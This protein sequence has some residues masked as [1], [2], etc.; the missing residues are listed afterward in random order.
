MAFLFC[1][2]GAWAFKDQSFGIG[3]GYYSQNVLNKIS[4]S[5][6]GKTS[7][8]GASMYP[9]S[10]QYD[11]RFGDAWYMTPRL[12]YTLATRSD[13][14]DSSK[15]SF[16]HLLLP[17]GTNLSEGSGS[18]WDWYAGPGLIQYKIAGAGGT[19]TMNNGTGTA[20]FARPGDDATILKVT[21]NLGT[22]RLFNQQTRIGA[23]L[24][25]ENLFSSSKRTQSL[26]LSYV[27]KFG[28]Y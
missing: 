4:S 10:F 7:F 17:F 9:F 11:Y 2:P 26:M 3:V 13:A 1:P 24:I 25:I 6:T 20:V 5:P 28:G 15:V 21:T 14:G 22:S 8:S 23:D 12:D 16:I 19:V 18:V 27:Y